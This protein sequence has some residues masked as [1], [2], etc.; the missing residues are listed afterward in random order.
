MLVV[1]AMLAGFG[2]GHAAWPPLDCGVAPGGDVTRDGIRCEP[3]R[4]WEFSF[5][6]A[7]LGLQWLVF[8]RPQRFSDGP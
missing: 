7:S 1:V 8:D 5:W 2:V 6:H 4:S 3:V